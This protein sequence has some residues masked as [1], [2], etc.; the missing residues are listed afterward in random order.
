MASATSVPGV[1]GTSDTGEISETREARGRRPVVD[2]RIR[3][4]RRFA[5]S[6]TAFN[7]LGHLWFGFE[8]AWA[9]PLM[10]LAVAY[11][12]D[13]ALEAIEAGTAGRRPRFAGGPVA[14]VNFLLPAHITALAVAMLLYAGSRLMPI[15]FAVAVAIS[16]KYVLRARVGET[17][18]HFFN[19]SNLGI[20]TTLLLFPSVGIA[21]PYHFTERLSGLLD[22]LVPGVILASGLVLNLKLT[23]RGPL[24]A[25]WVGGFAA[26]AV[27]RSVLFG[28]PVVAA[29]VPMTGVAFVLFTNYMITDPG[30]TPARPRNQA[31]FG[32]AAAATYGALVVGHVVFGLFFALAIVSAARGLLLWGSDLAAVAA[33]WLRRRPEGEGARRPATPMPEPVGVGAGAASQSAAP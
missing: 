7:V 6:I 19:P 28:T 30:T 33:G 8:Q 22:W 13:L 32:L 11:L 3:A 29:L 21:P 26:Q 20:V 2:V 12:L 14:L 27:V 23:R 17:S 15:A 18:R 5:V 1:A 10:A 25:G 16:S 31:L 4:L 9:H 24:I